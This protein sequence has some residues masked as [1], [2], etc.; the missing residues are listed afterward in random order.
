MFDLKKETRKKNLFLVLSV[1]FAFLFIAGVFC[2][3]M[4]EAS[5]VPFLVNGSPVKVVVPPALLF[6]LTFA[7]YR[8]SKKAIQENTEQ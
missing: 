1:I 4:G 2:T 3:V 5:P 7:L 6:F 8:N